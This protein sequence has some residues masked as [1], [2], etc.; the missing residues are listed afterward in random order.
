MGFRFGAKSIEHMTGVFPALLHAAHFALQ[1]SDIDFGFYEGLRTVEQEAENIKKGTS[2]LTDPTH[3][4]HC[5]QK[6]G[7]GHAMDLVPY[8]LGEDNNYHSVWD[9]PL[10]IKIAKLIQQYAFQNNLT[11]RWGGVWDMPLNKLSTNL[12]NE[13]LAYKSRFRKEHKREAFLDGVH[14]EI[15]MQN[16]T[17][18]DEA[19][20]AIIA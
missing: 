12:G 19:S 7:F 5:V 13:V 3:C 16:D 6:D 20:Q 2:H 4:M 14:F 15:P 11:I 17:P 10:C 9:W 18:N 1:N 8:I